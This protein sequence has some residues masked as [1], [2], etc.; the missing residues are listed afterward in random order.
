MNVEVV[1]AAAYAILSLLYYF[2]KKEA[3]SQIRILVGSILSVVVVLKWFL[4]L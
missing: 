3:F 2:S 4:E 1:L